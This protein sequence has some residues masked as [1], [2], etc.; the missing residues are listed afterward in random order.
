MLS[1]RVGLGTKFLTRPPSKLDTIHCPPYT[2]P[3]SHEHHH[4]TLY[5]KYET[6]PLRTWFHV[7]CLFHPLLSCSLP[8]SHLNTWNVSQSCVSGFAGYPLP[9]LP[10]PFHSSIKNVV[11]LS[12][13]SCH[14]AS[15]TQKT[16]PNGCVFCVQDLAHPSPPP[17]NTQNTLPRHVLCVQHLPLN[18]KNVTVASHFWC[19]LAILHCNRLPSSKALS[20]CLTSLLL[21]SFLYN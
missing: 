20:H 1:T 9:A 21:L 12:H 16:H 2:S 10:L 3:G 8:P 15:W 19:W 17:P 14:L 6:M 13:F 18:S 5:I 11:S 4:S 7:W